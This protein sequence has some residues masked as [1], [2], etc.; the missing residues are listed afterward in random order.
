MRKPDMS[1]VKA[2]RRELRVAREA[3]TGRAFTDTPELFKDIE[4]IKTRIRHQINP[5]YGDATHGQE[6]QRSRPC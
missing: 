2:L 1:M 6:R 4:S 5:I 3:V